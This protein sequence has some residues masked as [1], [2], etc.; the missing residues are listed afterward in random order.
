MSMTNGVLTVLPAPEGYVV[1]FAHP[2][3]QANIETY[4]V[5]AVGNFLSLLF[6]AQ[7]LYTKLGL[8]RTFQIDDGMF[9]TPPKPYIHL[10]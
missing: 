2:Q 4:W 1:D 8:N 3:R 7:R 6:I 5:A 9:L 10:F